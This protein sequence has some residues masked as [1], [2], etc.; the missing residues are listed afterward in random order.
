MSHDQTSISNN[1]MDEIGNVQRSVRQLMWLVGAN[2]VVTLV[3]FVMAM[4]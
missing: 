3:L 2:L 4:R 1:A